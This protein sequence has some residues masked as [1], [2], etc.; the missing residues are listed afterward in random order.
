M[1]YHG[2]TDIFREPKAAAGF[3]KSQCDRRQIVLEP[4]FHWAN[5][6]E[7]V[8]FTKLSSA[9]IAIISKYI[10]EKAVYRQVRRRSP[11]AELVERTEFNH[12]V[13]APFVWSYNNTDFR[14]L[15]F[16]WGDLRLDASHPRTAGDFEIILGSRG[17]SQI[18]DSP[19]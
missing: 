18:H 6:D 13:Y 9:R 11:P 16:R 2:V 8:G 19:G 4:A 12:L 10:C 15:G 1:C 3:Y 7:S 5:S 17:R 14:Q